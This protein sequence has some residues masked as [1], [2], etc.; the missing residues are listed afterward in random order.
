MKTLVVTALLACLTF[1]GCAG[2]PKPS[3]GPILPPADTQ[4]LLVSLGALQSAAVTLGPVDGIS[5][6]D[7]NTI[8]SVVG[9][10]IA[11]IE[12]G[13]TGW[14]SAVDVTLA[15]LPALLSPAT[16]ATIAPYLDAL[17]VVITDLYG[18]GVA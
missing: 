1:A 7:T 15:K 13:Q 18:S 10:A 8:V 4:L 6:A 14:V 12:A 17:Q 9:V 11:V 2:N 5:A 16:A 3:T